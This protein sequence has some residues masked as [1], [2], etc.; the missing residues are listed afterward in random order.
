MMTVLPL[1]LQVRAPVSVSKAVPLLH[2]SFPKGT[3]VPVL[4]GPV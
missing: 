4:S 2:T 3:N 1:A